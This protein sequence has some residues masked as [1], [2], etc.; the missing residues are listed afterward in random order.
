MSNDVFRSFMQIQI[1][2][3]MTRFINMNKTVLSYF[4]NINS[5]LL[6]TC[7]T[8]VRMCIHVKIIFQK[9][10]KTFIFIHRKNSLDM[11]IIIAT[12]IVIT[13]NLIRTIRTSKTRFRLC[14]SNPNAMVSLFRDEPTYTFKIQIT[15]IK[16]K[17]HTINLSGDNLTFFLSVYSMC[18][19]KFNP[20]YFILIVTYTVWT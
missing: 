13:I 3:T 19:L 10:D 18:A 6:T 2:F 12:M 15:A 9:V 5:Q 14:I 16:I 1:I 7:Q 20:Q 4:I 11:I 8:V 17:L